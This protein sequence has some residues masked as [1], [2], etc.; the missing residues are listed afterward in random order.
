MDCFITRAW[1]STEFPIPTVCR[2]GDP[3]EKCASTDGR[4]LSDGG[5]RLVGDGGVEVQVGEEGEVQVTGPEMLVGYLDQELNEAAFTT[6]GWFRSGDLGR[7][8][9]DG[10]LTITGRIKDIIIRGGENISAKEIEDLLFEHEDVEEVSVV[11]KPD[12]TMGERVCAVVLPVAGTE[13]TLQSLIDFLRAKGIANQ[14]LP[15]HLLI[16]DELPRTASGK[17]QKFHLRKQLGS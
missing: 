6:D 17:V 9:A 2:P 8:D 12:A 16:V 10:Y 1:G 4:L 15:E 7:L 5:L 11:G 13:P 14:K 3:L